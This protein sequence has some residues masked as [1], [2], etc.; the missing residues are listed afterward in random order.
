LPDASTEKETAAFWQDMRKVAVDTLQCRTLRLPERLQLLT[1]LAGVLSPAQ[2]QRNLAEMLRIVR[3]FSPHTMT[4]RQMTPGVRAFGEL[5]YMIGWL[6]EG[7]QS[8]E[9][10]WQQC[11]A[12][13]QLTGGRADWTGEDVV[14]AL[15]IY[16]AQAEIFASVY[17]N[18]P[19]YYEHMLVNHV[20]VADYPFGEWHESIMERQEALCMTYVMLRF[21]GV[22]SAQKAH[23]EALIDIH[24]N[25]FHLIEHS[26]FYQTAP[27]MAAKLHIDAQQIQC[28]TQF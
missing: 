2:K 10:P 16:Q 14:R 17:Q 24:T 21:F 26:N 12:A 18:W 20:L 13:L 3:A 25:C 9:A 11:C 28:L 8:M 19:T 7:S 15:E 4:Q 27:R 6:C 22:M 1:E 5:L 23:A